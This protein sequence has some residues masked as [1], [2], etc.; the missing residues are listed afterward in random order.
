MLTQ[1]FNLQ[2]QLLLDNQEKALK[3]HL[4]EYLDQHRRLEDA[5]GTKKQP[6]SA[7]SESSEARSPAKKS[8]VKHKLQEFVLQVSCH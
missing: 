7:A 8:D 6:Q 5:V 2:K 1:Q 3:K 4:I